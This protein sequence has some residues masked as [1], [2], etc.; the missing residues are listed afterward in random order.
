MHHGSDTTP[1]LSRTLRFLQA[2]QYTG[3]TTQELQLFTG[4]MA[5]AT[6]CSELRRSGHLI[7]CKSEGMNGNGR[8]VYRYFYRGKKDE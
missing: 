1:R 7:E 4:S 2:H 8:R 6:D 3:C 5:P